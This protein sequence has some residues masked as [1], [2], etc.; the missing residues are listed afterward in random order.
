MRPEHY[1]LVGL[2]ALV[3]LYFTRP[4]WARDPGG[5]DDSLRTFYLPPYDK[6]QHFAIAAALTALAS[7]LT[8]DPWS[9]AHITVALGIGW[10]VVEWQFGRGKFSWLDVVADAA[11]AYLVLAILLHL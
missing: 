11:G 1:A 10:E 4:P 7:W 6:L 5:Y 2:V 9:C 8:R 3:V